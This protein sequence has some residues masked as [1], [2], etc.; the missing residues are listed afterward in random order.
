MFEI[1]QWPEWHIEE[2]RQYY[3]LRPFGAWRDNYHAAMITDTLARV[4][5]NKIPFGNWFFK[6]AL[7]IEQ[8]RKANDLAAFEN[9][10]G[11]VQRAEDAKG[12]VDG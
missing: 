12:D 11:I 5:G 2:W 1:E 7:T 8:D 3:A 4:N 10:V 6:D 9:I